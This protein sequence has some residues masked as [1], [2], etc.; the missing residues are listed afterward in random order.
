M[1]TS[2][3]INH[4]KLAESRL[5]TQF[6]ESV[7]LI[8]Y[9]KALLLEAD[10]LEQ[11]FRSLLEDRWIDTATGIQLDI[12]GSI[13]G[14]Q[15]VLVDSSLL[16]YFGFDPYPTAASFG[17]VGNPTIGERFRGVEEPI[18]GNRTLSDDEY[19]LYI[20]ARII[21]NSII[22]TVQNM[23]SLLKFIFNVEQVIVVDGPM[24]YAVSIGRPLTPNEK[25]FVENENLLPKV[26]AVGVG[27]RE[28]EANNAM[29][30]APIPTAK[31]FGSV[32]DSSI[33]GKF[34]TI[35]F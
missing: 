10:N 25:V 13:V 35:L 7:N 8:N 34:S 32:N 27:Y 26:A 5:A 29:G 19:R 17:T 21:K 4:K 3:T 33:G 16:T 9:I 23:Q 24:R 18:T 11:V 12:I 14:Q 1:T 2:V 15:R 31:G 22:P 30:F 20:R 6:K 28:Y